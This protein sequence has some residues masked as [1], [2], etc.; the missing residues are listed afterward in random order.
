MTRTDGV[1]STAYC[2]RVAYS[3]V[4]VTGLL[5]LSIGHYRPKGH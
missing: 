2:T 5:G 4:S 3:Q 1:Q